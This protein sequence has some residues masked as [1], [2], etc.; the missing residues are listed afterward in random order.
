MFIL[1][2]IINHRGAFTNL[3]TR[4]PGSVPDVRIF[5]E[6]SVGFNIDHGAIEGY[7][8]L[9]DSGY[10]LRPSMLIPFPVEEAF[11]DPIKSEYVFVFKLNC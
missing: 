9:G 8:L 1:K 7:W 11:A 2:V 5:G 4:W 3:V 6:S 10:C